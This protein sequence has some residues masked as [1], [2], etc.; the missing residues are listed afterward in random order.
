MIYRITRDTGKTV[1]RIN[2]LTGK[3]SAY[4]RSGGYQP[5]DQ[6]WIDTGK[7]ST[8]SKPTRAEATFIP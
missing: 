5:I 8:P 1:Y 4:Q 3:R 2:R 7:W 6:Q